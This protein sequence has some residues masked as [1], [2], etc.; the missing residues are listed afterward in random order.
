MTF[1]VLISNA[2]DKMYSN[3][4]NALVEKYGKPTRESDM[5]GKKVQWKSEVKDTLIL[6]NYTEENLNGDYKI[7][8]HYRN[9]KYY[10]DNYDDAYFPKS[11]GI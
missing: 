4:L 10:D 5:L 7:V 9:K 3:V 6:C 8:I 11:N 1:Y 2:N